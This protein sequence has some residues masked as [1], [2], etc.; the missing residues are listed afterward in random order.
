MCHYL[1]EHLYL[2]LPFFLRIKVEMTAE[3]KGRQTLSILEGEL[4]LLSPPNQCYP[5]VPPS[6]YV[7]QIWRDGACQNMSASVPPSPVCLSVLP[8]LLDMTRQIR[9]CNLNIFKANVKRSKS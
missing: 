7:V 6:L 3:E 5:S 2:P 4:R 8:L 1:Q 9:K